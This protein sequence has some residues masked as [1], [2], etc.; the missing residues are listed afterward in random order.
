MW[1]EM[2]TMFG[3]KG[4]QSVELNNP[5]M[6]LFYGVDT[7]TQRLTAV[8]MISDAEMH[9]MNRMQYQAYLSTMLK[10]L[11][12]RAPRTRI[13]SLFMT[14]D[15]DYVNLIAGQMDPMMFGYYI[16]NPIG[17]QILVDPY[18]DYNNMPWIS[19]ELAQLLED[20]R[21]K[22]M[23]GVTIQPDWADPVLWKQDTAHSQEEVRSWYT[24]RG[25][26]LKCK[27]TMYLIIIN[28]VVFLFTLVAA[29]AGRAEDLVRWG[30]ASGE[31]VFGKFQIHRLL[32]STFLHAGIAHIVGNMVFLFAFGD[33]VEQYMKSKKYTLLYLI[34]GV[35]ASFGAVLWR[36]ITGSYELLGIGA[37]GAVFGIMGAL[38]VLM[39]RHP[40]LR[41]TS[42]GVPFWAIPAYVVY[43]ICEPLVLGAILDQETNIDLAAHVSGFIVGAVLFWY[44]EKKK[45][46]Q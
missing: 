27:Q 6:A 20:D 33:V 1:A 28:A 46:K 44:M 13:I 39:F 8:W 37:S 32:T 14:S 10:K 41:K 12:G 23:A 9:R 29:I 19:D 2:K 16:V 36:T 35:G 17:S 40:E 3:E 24:G 31:T 45:A 34:A 15:I 21:V 11:R 4:F 5:G 30:G 22:T 38:T 7:G 25:K 43:S 42:K 18:R 26:R